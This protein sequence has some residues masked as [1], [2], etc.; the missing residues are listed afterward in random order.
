MFCFKNYVFLWDCLRLEEEK[1]Q[2]QQRIWQT[3][4]I[5]LIILEIILE[6]ILDLQG[7]FQLFKYSTSVVYGSGIEKRTI[8][9]MPKHK[10]EM[11]HSKV[12]NGTSK[13]ETF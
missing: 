9:I 4:Y 12:Y 11:I 5:R 10:A 3:N 2:Q 13:K 7:Q 8:Q 1:Q 6:I